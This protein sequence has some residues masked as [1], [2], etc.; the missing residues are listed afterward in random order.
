MYFQSTKQALYVNYCEWNAVPEAKSESSPIIVKC[1]ETFELENDIAIAMAFNPNVFVEH[2]FPMDPSESNEEALLLAVDRKTEDNR[3]QLIWLGLHFLDMEKKL[4]TVE[5]NSVICSSAPLR[6][7]VL[8]PDDRYGKSE[9]ILQSLGYYARL[10][11]TVQKSEEQPGFSSVNSLKINDMV[12]QLGQEGNLTDDLTAQPDSENQDRTFFSQSEPLKLPQDLPV[13]KPQKKLIEELPGE[14]LKTINWR[15]EVVAAIQTGKSDT[16]RPNQLKLTFDL[17]GVTSG[18]QCDLDITNK[19]LLLSILASPEK[20][21][22]LEFELPC[23]IIAEKAEAKFNGKREK[24]TVYA[25]ILN[26]DS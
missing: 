12:K 2:D 20:Y 11:K 1:G 19:K 21:R 26:S 22:P 9:Q 14:K 6:P 13:K 17:P 24:L 3:Y 5:S 7:K 25:P 10:R 18:T 16:N 8:R 4:T 15:A 23:D